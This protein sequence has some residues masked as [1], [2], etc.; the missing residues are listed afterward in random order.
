MA[1]NLLEL[2]FFIELH[3]KRHKDKKIWKNTYHYLQIKVW[4]LMKFIGVLIL[5]IWQR[6][7]SMSM[8]KGLTFYVRHL[9]ELKNV[10]L[11]MGG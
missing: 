8:S 9:I 3:T 2:D 1:C 7:I 4:K 5:E 10:I 6:K 11:F